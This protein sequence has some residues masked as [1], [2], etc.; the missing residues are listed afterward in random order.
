MRMSDWSSD[1]C[2]SDLLP[3][4]WFAARRLRPDMNLLMVI[5]VIGAVGIGELFEAATVA[6][7]FALSLALESWRVGRARRAISALLDL[8]PPTVRARADD[9]HDHELPDADVAVGTPSI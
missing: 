8:A 5:A 2:S 6:F 1:V 3:K 4:A 9:G 7:L